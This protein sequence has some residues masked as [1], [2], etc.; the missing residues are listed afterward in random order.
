MASLIVDAESVEA[1]IPVTGALID[2]AA[3]IL[4]TEGDP[5]PLVRAI[6]LAGAASGESLSA[7][8]MRLSHEQALDNQ[9]KRLTIIGSL[10]VVATGLVTAGTFAAGGLRRSP[11][12]AGDWNPYGH[13]REPVRYPERSALK[14][15]RID[16]A[17]TLRSG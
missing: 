17:S 14:A 1:C 11:A 5:S 7:E 6:A 13:R 2:Q 10:S 9:R 16:R 3:L 12:H 15:L 8:L 4:H